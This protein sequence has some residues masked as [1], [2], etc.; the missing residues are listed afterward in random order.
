MKQHGI[1]IPIIAI[2]GIGYDDINSLLKTGLNGIALSGAILQ[3]DNPI[4]EMQRIMT[5]KSL[6][7]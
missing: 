4:A 1:N 6:H 7:S 3:A 5:I 2:G